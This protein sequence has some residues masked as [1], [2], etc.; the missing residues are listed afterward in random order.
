MS[1]TLSEFYASAKQNKLP[2]PRD[3]AAG[4]TQSGLSSPASNHLPNRRQIL[5]IQEN[6]SPT[7]PIAS[8]SHVIPSIG[9][10]VRSSARSIDGNLSGSLDLLGGLTQKSNSALNGARNNHPFGSLNLLSSG[11]PTISG[12]S[13][14]SQ[15]PLP[16]SAGNSPSRVLPPIPGRN[17]VDNRKGLPI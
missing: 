4:P 14:G 12:R 6:G 3:L 9:S 1:P 8:P 17:A 2:S 15:R 10:P 13:P 7:H 5:T 11:S 16:G